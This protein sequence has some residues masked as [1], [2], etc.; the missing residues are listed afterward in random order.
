[1][2]LQDIG[3][4]IVG[5]GFM[6]PAHTEALR[7]VGVDV[8]GI[9]GSSPSKSARAAE[10]L[11][12]PT[13]Y[14][15]YDDLLADDSVHAVHITTPNKFH[16][17]MVIAALDAGKHVLCEKPLAM[18]SAESLDLVR[19]AEASG[20]HAGVNYNIRFY[21]SCLEAAARDVGKVHS[22][23]GSY[24][25]DWLL[26]DTDYNW[27]VLASEGGELRAIADIG[28][29]WLDLV[30]FVTGDRVASVMADLKTIHPV[31]RRPKGEVETFSNV[32]ATDLIETAIETEDQGAVLIRFQ[33]G[34]TGML[35]V[36]Q[37]TA[38]R[39]NR[40]QFEIGG[41]HGSI[42]WDS[43]SANHLWLG[44]RTKPNELLDK[45]ASLMS[46]GAA[47]HASYPG[48]HAE[49]YPDSFKQCF[50]AFYDA[51]R[52]EPGPVAYPSFA[53]GHREIRI[54]EAILASHR[55]GAWQAVE[56]DL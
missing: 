35:W 54:C 27:R 5:T 48:G 15:S 56:E 8:R 40:L 53:D 20:L 36:S 29:H 49:G 12:I 3:V 46:R 55:A 28:T 30:T 6:G 33:S 25:Q 21:P 26:Y 42:A 45:D 19:R 23:Q 52:G 13:G 4:A 44:H 22:V 11:G 9:L 47:Y 18:T 51:I 37:A 43:D 31:R 7:R 39:K 2:K 32:Q 17:A 14:R 34:A 50:R 1:M 41:A 10:S 16:H 38:G 24:V